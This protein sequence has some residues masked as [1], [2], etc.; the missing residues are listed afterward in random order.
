MKLL[1]SISKYYIW[2]HTTVNWKSVNLCRRVWV[3]F[4]F[5]LDFNFIHAPYKYS[6]RFMS[7]KMNKQFVKAGNKGEK[8]VGQ[9]WFLRLISFFKCV[10]WCYSQKSAIPTEWECCN[11]CRV[12][13]VLPKESMIMFI[14][15][16]KFR[17]RSPKNHQTSNSCL[18]DTASSCCF[19]PTH[20][21]N[22]HNLR[23]QKYHSWRLNVNEIIG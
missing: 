18:P 1:Q 5:W 8:D 20:S 4:W 3:S 10:T 13:W 23:S 11:A 6:I 14:L 12:L 17:T 16:E 19:H 7:A 15:N 22:H 2:K 9:D 21:Q